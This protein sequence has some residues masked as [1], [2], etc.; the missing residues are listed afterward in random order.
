ME[1]GTFTSKAPYAGPLTNIK[2]QNQNTK[3]E[4]NPVTFSDPS[5]HAAKSGGL[6][7]LQ[8]NIRIANGGNGPALKP[9]VNNPTAAAK[10]IY[11]SRRDAV[12]LFFVYTLLDNIRVYNGKDR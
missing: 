8:N 4:N 6:S 5:G 10:A 2:K 3:A 7:S 11:Q 1:T 9:V 12:V